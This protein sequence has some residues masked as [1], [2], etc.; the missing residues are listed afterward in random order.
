[1]RL[2]T[3]LA[4]CLGLSATAAA[5][6]PAPAKPYT[7]LPT[8]MNYA[9]LDPSLEAF[10]GQLREIVKR[11][12]KAAL[13]AHVIAKG[14]FWD[15]DEHRVFD[16]KKSGFDN[17]VLAYDFDNPSSGGWDTLDQ[18]LT[19]KLAT[20]HPKRQGVVCLPARP[21]TSEKE[22]TAHAKRLGISALNLV[23]PRSEGVPVYEKPEQGARVVETL[24][25]HWVRRLD[26]VDRK[27]ENWPPHKAW[28]QVVTPAGTTAYA[29]PDTL[30]FFSTQTCFAKDA[31]GAWKIA[32]TA[33]Y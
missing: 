23:Y 27:G 11:K 4:L 31:T 25:A 1:M 5:Q 9:T 17:L 19:E 18:A 10:R 13:R 33:P 16:R 20:W 32:G 15:N 26:W 2:L 22:L 3:C 14:F 6:A 29:A 7:P 8:A 24:G 12:D 28:N 30:V 21:A